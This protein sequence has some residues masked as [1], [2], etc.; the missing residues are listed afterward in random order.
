MLEHYHLTNA[1]CQ[2]HGRNEYAEFPEAKGQ[3][4]DF[5]LV[6]GIRRSDCIS[7]ALDHLK[8]DG[9]IY[10]DNSDTD[11]G[12]GEMRTAV[13]RLNEAAIEREGACSSFTDFVPG[14]FFGTEGVLVGFGRYEPLL[15]QLSSLIKF[16]SKC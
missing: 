9:L 4:F 16:K 10:L 7:F 13:A 2:L 12:G 3:K 5:V 11:S 14:N 1:E 8:P 15:H 6:D